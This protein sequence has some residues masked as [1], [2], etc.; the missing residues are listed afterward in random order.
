MWDA[1]VVLLGLACI[2]YSLLAMVAAGGGGTGLLP[3]LVC[4]RVHVCVW[5]KQL[6]M[7]STASALLYCLLLL[8]ARGCW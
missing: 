2:V 6:S 8:I 7:D 4:V 3:L 5:R 1:R